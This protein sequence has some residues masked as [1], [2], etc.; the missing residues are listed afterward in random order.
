MYSFNWISYITQ[1]QWEIIGRAFNVRPSEC[2]VYLVPTRNALHSSL[3]SFNSSNLLK[4]NGIESLFELHAK[5]TGD[6]V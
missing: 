2:R 3:M 5:P 1:E 6:L 4:S